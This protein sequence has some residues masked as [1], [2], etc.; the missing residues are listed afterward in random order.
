MKDRKA[1]DNR[2]PESQPS[3]AFE[4]ESLVEDVSGDQWL[5]QRMEPG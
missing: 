4:S 2:L 3:V 1:S 5:T